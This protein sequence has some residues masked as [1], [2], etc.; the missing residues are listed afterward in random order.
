MKD[1]INQ[2][3][4]FDYNIFNGKLTD[5]FKNGFEQKSKLILNTINPHSFIVATKDK[6][7][8]NALQNADYL[9]ADGIG[10]TL[11][12]S[13]FFNK[14]I[15]LINGPMIHQF[16]LDNYLYN[17]FKVVYM[18]SSENS[19]LLIKKKLENMGSNWE[20]YT[21]SPPFKDEF[22]LEDNNAI[23]D[24]INQIKPHIVFV[25]MTAPKQEKWVMANADNIITSYILSIGAVFDF[26]AETKYMG[27]RIIQK[28]NLIWAYR[29][30]TNFR[31]VWKRTF[32]SLP[33]FIFYNIFPK[34]YYKK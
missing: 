8:K 27:P 25:G 15:E 29:L 28:F 23:V 3:S 19:L 13:I 12:A 7:Y 21:Y 18:G 30:L 14:K 17:K 4:F 26:F 32:I 6:F 20:V 16:I 2:I 11:M 34:K 5:V 9:F 33:V 31:N 10:I 22:T 24:F 1:S